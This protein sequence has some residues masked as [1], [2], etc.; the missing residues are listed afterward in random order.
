MAAKADVFEQGRGEKA[1]VRDG[2]DV[3]DSTTWLIDMPFR[4]TPETNVSDFN[5]MARSKR[6]AG[7]A[8]SVAP[9]LNRAVNDRRR[10]G[11]RIT[12]LYF[13]RFA[14][15]ELDD[16]NLPSA[17]KT[18]RDFICECF[19]QDDS[20][21]SGIDFKYFQAPSK[22]YSIL[23]KMTVIAKEKNDERRRTETPVRP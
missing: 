12:A 23:V 9:Y 18:I 4:V 8:R 3:G 22:E 6:R 1:R 21:R 13:A 11:L 2:H 17:F 19:G 14:P 20:H 16:D 5:F 15:G 10:M 7:I